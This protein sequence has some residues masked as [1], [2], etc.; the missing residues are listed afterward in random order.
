MDAANAKT[1]HELDGRKIDLKPAVPRSESRRDRDQQQ[2]QQQ[3]SD[4]RTNKVFV[5]GL[6][7]D[8]T[9]ESMDEHFS[10][11]ENAPARESRPSP[12]EQTQTQPEHAINE[13]PHHHP[14]LL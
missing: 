12:P 6:S 8:T 14:S 5:G 7:M 2:D 11:Y 9:K 3:D 10:K 4:I 13:T 1:D